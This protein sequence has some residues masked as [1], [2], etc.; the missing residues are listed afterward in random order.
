[1]LFALVLALVALT[2]C[3]R[4]SGGV[5]ADRGGPADAHAA[6]APLEASA[7]AP[8][9]EDRRLRLVEAMSALIDAHYVFPD[10]GTQVAASLREHAARG[11][12]AAAAGGDD[13]AALVTQHLRAVSH[14]LHFRL[15]YDSGPDVPATPAEEAEEKAEAALDARFGFVATE[16]LPGNVALIRID[17]FRQGAG[18]PGVAAAYAAR[19]S[20]VADAS[21][22]ILDLRE[23]RGG[24]PSTGLLLLSYLFD[25]RPVHLA[26]ISSRDG[27]TWPL[28]TRAQVE[29]TR[30]GGKKPIYVL[31]S[32]RTF[33][34]AEGVA[35]DLQ[36]QRHAIVVGERTRGGAHPT[37]L[38]KLDENFSLGVP[39]ART[40]STVT[41]TNW[42]GVGVVPDVAV[43][44][45]DAVHEAM[46]LV[47]GERGRSRR[48]PVPSSSPA[49]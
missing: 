44:A 49:E 31:T 4:S 43:D 41:H 11:D 13:F 37:P 20:E 16:R 35:Y 27:S 47:R 21:A 5:S 33:S 17:S 2:G 9:T 22:L 19:M 30:F 24:D 14:D 34:G 29:G 39:S 32:Q 40:I 8:L 15:E 7:P 46:G 26:D 48:A 3:S 38:Y 36:T 6:P 25:P 45:A 12:Y 10:V 28:W 18:A 23:N 42:E 1:M